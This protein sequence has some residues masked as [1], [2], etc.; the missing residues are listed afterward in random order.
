[1]AISKVYYLIRDCVPDPVWARIEALMDI[2]QPLKRKNLLNA[3]HL[4]Q[5]LKT[6]YG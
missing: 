2:T 6:E 1:V 3:L 4:F 5:F